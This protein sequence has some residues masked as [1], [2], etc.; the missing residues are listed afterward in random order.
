MCIRDSFQSAWVDTGILGLRDPDSL[1]GWPKFGD[2]VLSFSGTDQDDNSGTS[3]NVLTAGGEVTNHHGYI[4][5]SAGSTGEATVTGF[6]GWTHSGVLSVGQRGSGTLNITDGGE[7]TNTSVSY[8]GFIGRYPDSFAGITSWAIRSGPS[9]L[10]SSSS[11]PDANPPVGFPIQRQGLLWC[12]NG[13][14]AEV[15]RTVSG[16]CRLIEENANFTIA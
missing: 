1:G 12:S 10:A 8:D 11:L 7:V 16:K 6:S 3:G 9:R 2:S 14:A 15:G 5:Y 13:P 4:G